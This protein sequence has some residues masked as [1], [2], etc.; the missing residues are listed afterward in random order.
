MSCQARV[1]D[2]FAHLKLGMETLATGT[3]THD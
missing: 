3:K 2:M 1:M